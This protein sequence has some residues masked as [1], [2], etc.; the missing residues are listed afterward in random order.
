VIELLL[1]DM[2]VLEC[3]IAYSKCFSKTVES[4]KFI[5]F[6]DKLLPDMYYHN[7]TLLSDYCSDTEIYQQIEKEI[8]LRKMKNEKF[9]NIV[10]LPPIP[11]NLLDKFTIKP[12]ISI[13]GFYLFDNDKLSSLLR[14]IEYNISQV[15]S[16][17]MIDELILLEL[18]QH[19]E[20]FGQDFCKRKINRYKDAYLATG[21]VYSYICYDSSGKAVG[22][23]ELFIYNGIA[24]IERLSVSPKSQCLGYG[25]AILRTMIEIALENNASKIYLIADE[26][27]TPKNIYLKY[28]FKKIAEKNDLFFEI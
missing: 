27:D 25:I 14:K 19:G 16:S 3:E 20:L 21:G 2:Q 1:T 5:R 13:E 22:N 9:C 28:G 26:N 23:C 24:K 10:S 15:N 4:E 6:C 8:T 17:K 7:F 18:E 11:K 12:Q